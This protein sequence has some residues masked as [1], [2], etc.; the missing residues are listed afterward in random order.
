MYIGI[1][2]YRIDTEIMELDEFRK[3]LEIAREDEVLMSLQGKLVGTHQSASILEDEESCIL[4][5][6]KQQC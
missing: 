5:F 1:A 3:C 4:S 6:L 2:L